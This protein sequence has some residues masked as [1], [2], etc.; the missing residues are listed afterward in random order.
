VAA[1]ALIDAFDR[2]FLQK[3]ILGTR[4]EFG[5]PGFCVL[6]SWAVRFWPRFAR[7]RLVKK[8]ACAPED[9]LC[10]SIHLSGQA[11]NLESWKYNEHAHGDADASKPDQSLSERFGT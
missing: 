7:M 11:K 9:Q 10:A 4:Q 5:L 2:P 3:L 6:A 1:L 8:I